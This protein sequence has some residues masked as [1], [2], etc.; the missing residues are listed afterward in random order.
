MFKWVDILITSVWQTNILAS[1]RRASYWQFLFAKFKCIKAQFKVIKTT[2][3]MFL[4]KYICRRFSPI[5]FGDSST[6][7]HM[8]TIVWIKICAFVKWNSTSSTVENNTLFVS[9]RR[10]F[11]CSRSSYGRKNHVYS[12][13]RWSTMWKGWLR[14][15]LLIWR[16]VVWSLALTCRSH[17]G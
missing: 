3:H 9:P 8:S 4:N 6:L 10:Q 7:F 12:V 17:F 1:V 16:S 13:F 2:F 14:W 15:Y 5:L 11:P